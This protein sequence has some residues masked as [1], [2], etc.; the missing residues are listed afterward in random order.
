MRIRLHSAIRTLAAAVLLTSALVTVASPA[1]AAGGEQGELLL[2]GPGTVYGG[3]ASLASLSVAPGTAAAFSFEVR[4]TGPSTAQY[5]IQLSSAG[6]VCAA[7]C[8]SSA[9]ITTGSLVVTQLAAG[10]N[11]YFTA[12]IAPGATAVYSL[13]ITE[14]KTGATPGDDVIYQLR[15][16]DT[17]GAALGSSSTVYVN[18]T[19]ST[20]T[21]AAEQFLSASGTPS[22]SGNASSFGIV[23][24]PSVTVD[25]A[26]SFTVKL[27][28]D[29]ASPTPIAYVLN[30]GQPNCSAYFPIKV[31]QSSTLGGTNVTAAVTGGTYSTPAL[32]HGASV[33]LTVS[34]TSLAGGL[35]CLLGY[36]N[37]FADWSGV[38]SADNQSTLGYLIFSPAAL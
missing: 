24:A 38:A 9:V 37:G 8:T 35:Q 12:P 36:G 26:F 22:T 19:R 2:K 25:K 34:G 3:P 6:N 33:T 4:N 17:A 15:L 14:S 11:G 10:P 1:T 29:S 21:R 5:N 27:T 20:G 18:A 28:N 30:F 7:A 23:T 16:S 31:V 13:K 32:G